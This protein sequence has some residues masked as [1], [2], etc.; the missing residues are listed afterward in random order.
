[1]GFTDTLWER[2]RSLY[3]AILELPFNVELCTGDLSE[4]RFA[5][6]VKQDSLYL[7]DFSRALAVTGTRTPD[8]DALGS[9]LEFAGEAVSVE[10][11]LHDRALGGLS[12]RQR[13][14]L[15]DLALLLGA[16]EALLHRHAV[17]L[18][19]LL[20]PVNVSQQVLRL[21]IGLVCGLPRPGLERQQAR[22]RHRA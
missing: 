12:Q 6:Y 9:F 18:A 17:A 14:R 13:R 22:R 4:D 5:F 7:A 11:A 1:M 19:P 8:N 21:R 3:D 2:N 20:L 16:L 15:H 10:Q